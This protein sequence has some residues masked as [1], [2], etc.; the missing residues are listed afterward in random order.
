MLRNGQFQVVYRNQ[1]KTWSLR[2]RGNQYVDVRFV[3]AEKAKF[4]AKATTHAKVLSVAKGAGALANVVGGIILVKDVADEGWTA[5]NQMDAAIYG[6]GFIPVVGWGLS[7]LMAGAK[8]VGEGMHRQSMQWNNQ[9]DFK[10][11]D[12]ADQAEADRT[13]APYSHPYQMFE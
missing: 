4:L 8:A 5:D 6:V 7:P 9:S 11:V 10:T 1:Q 2:F 13:M 3:N 12:P